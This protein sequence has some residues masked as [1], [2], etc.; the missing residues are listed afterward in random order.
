MTAPT[1]ADAAAAADRFADRVFD[2]RR[3]NPQTETP[4][5]RRARLR[6]D[7]AHQAEQLG[8]AAHGLRCFHEDLDLALEQYFRTAA[9]LDVAMDAFDAAL[10]ETRIPQPHVA[11]RPT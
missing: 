2:P 10:S 4:A 3:A 1:P 9:R 6:D 5:Q 11:D 8:K 7:V